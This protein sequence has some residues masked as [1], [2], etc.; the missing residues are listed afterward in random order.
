MSKILII[1]DEAAVQGFNKYRK[2]D[3]YKV[4][5]AEDGLQAWRIKTKT[6]LVLCDIQ[7][8]QNGWRRSFGS[9]E[10]NKT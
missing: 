10:K 9:R 4:D 3:T 5:E 1:K 2:S 6:D 7:N 8:A